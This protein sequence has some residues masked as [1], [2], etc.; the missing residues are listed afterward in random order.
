[1]D[2]TRH[3]DVCGRVSCR[4]GRIEK[5]M[6]EPV[7][8]LN[9]LGAVVATLFVRSQE[10]EI[11]AERVRAVFV[12]DGVG[13]NHIALRLRHLRAF[14]DDQPVRPEPRKRFLEVDVAQVLQHHAQEARVHEMQDR[15]LI[16]TDVHVDRQPLASDD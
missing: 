12:D 16:A 2:L 11:R 8:A 15:M 4:H 7:W 5:T 9:A 13:D 10:H 3:I 1:M 6:Q 14:G